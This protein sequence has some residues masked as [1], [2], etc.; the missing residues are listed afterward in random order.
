L[1]SLKICFVYNNVIAQ[2]QTIS[3]DEKET[4]FWFPTR[5]VK[6]GQTE[7]LKLIM[8]IHFV[9]DIFGGKFV[10]GI[11]RQKSGWVHSELRPQQQQLPTVL[12]TDTITKNVKN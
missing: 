11:D 9:N 10:A 3:Y 12:M 8:I 4:N 5:A 2:T 7:T 1:L 6:I